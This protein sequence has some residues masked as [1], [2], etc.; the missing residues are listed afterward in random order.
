M[1]RRTTES[2]TIDYIRSITAPLLAD[3]P[4][5]SLAV[6][7]SNPSTV[8]IHLATPPTTIKKEK[9]GRQYTSP[10]RQQNMS[11]EKIAS[12]KRSPRPSP[13][14]LA[15]AEE[16][17]KKKEKPKVRAS[18]LKMKYLEP[19]GIK[20]SPYERANKLKLKEEARMLHEKE[21][22][23]KERALTPQQKDEAWAD[24]LLRERKWQEQK[25]NRIVQQRIEK[26]CKEDNRPLRH[27]RDARPL[28]NDQ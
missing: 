3:S 1:K 4:C 5:P 17:Q 19:K 9:Y 28:T 14:S 25:K 10:Y 16:E 26:K 22:R 7:S 2:Q 6:S 24:F 15:A 20:P 18:S 21:R 23:S 27:S 13:F 8:T 11:I 12:T